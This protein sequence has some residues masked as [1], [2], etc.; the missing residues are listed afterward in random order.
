MA[1]TPDTAGALCVILGGG[2]HARVLVDALTSGGLGLSCVILDADSSKWGSR[3]YDV[4]ILGGDELLPGLAQRG[5][6]HFVVGLGSTGDN[7]N[8]RRLFELGLAH[9]LKPVTVMHPTAVCSRW[10]TVGVGCQLLPGSIVNAGSRLGTNVLINSGAI[11]EHD[12]VLGDHVHVA[13]GARLASTVRVAAEAHIGAGASVRQCIAIGEGAIVGVGAA[14]VTDVLPF[15]TVV[16]VPAR[17][18]E[19]HRPIVTAS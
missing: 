14:V 17:P 5:V 4:P 3:L 1:I 13:T 10:A 2:G 19:K 12:C 8:R 6:V 7:R 15:T 11:V 9:G 18:L 16:G